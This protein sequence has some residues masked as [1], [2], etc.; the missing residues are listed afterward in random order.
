MWW[1][2]GTDSWTHLN[3]WRDHLARPLGETPYLAGT[4]YGDIVTMVSG[5]GGQVVDVGTLGRT[6]GHT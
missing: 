2:T 4:K 6:L 1:D 3:I 5:L